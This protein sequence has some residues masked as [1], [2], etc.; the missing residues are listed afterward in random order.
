MSIDENMEIQAEEFKTKGGKAAPQ[1][2][3]TFAELEEKIDVVLKKEFVNHMNK[4]A[5]EDLNSIIK[6]QPRLAYYDHVNFL[7]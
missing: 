3:F 5:L 2:T 6:E 1:R 7:L 4:G